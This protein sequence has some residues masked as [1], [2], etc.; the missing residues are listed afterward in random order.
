MTIPLNC[1]HCRANLDI[2]D[3]YEV[4]LSKCDGDIVKAAEWAAHY[5]VTFNKPGRFSRIVSIYDRGSD[6]HS[7]YE[8][9][10]CKKVIEV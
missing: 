7:R 6:R 9:P 2:G 1:P 5:G 3:I 8:C 4:M 10:D